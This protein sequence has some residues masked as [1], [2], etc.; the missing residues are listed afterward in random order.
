MPLLFRDSGEVGKK[1]GAGSAVDKVWA[2]TR[3]QGRTFVDLIKGVGAHHQGVRAAGHYCL[4][5]GK[6]GLTGAVDGQYLIPCIYARQAE[7]ALQPVGDGGAQ[8]WQ[9]RSGRVVGQAL[10][11]GGD[12][13]HDE[14]RRGVARFADR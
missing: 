11:V 10:Q 7:P 3:Q 8:F 6:Q 2:G 4:G 13:L 14:G 5:E 1:T 12:F 9:A